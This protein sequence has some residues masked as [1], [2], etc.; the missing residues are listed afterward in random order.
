M[1]NP[2]SAMPEVSMDRQISNFSQ[3]IVAIEN[4]AINHELSEA[5]REIN[6]RL[7]QIVIENGGKPTA[8]LTLKLKFKLDSGMIELVPDVITKLPKVP[9]SKNVFFCTPGNL[10]TKHD[11]RQTEMKFRDVNAPQTTETRVG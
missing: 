11:P 10:L 7:N 9:R 2:S 1:A 3:L 6:A 5:I 8:E 4:G